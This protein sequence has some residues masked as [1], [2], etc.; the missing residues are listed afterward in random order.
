[1]VFLLLIPFWLSFFKAME[2]MFTSAATANYAYVYMA[3]SLSLNAP[4][5]CSAYIGSDNKF[6]TQHVTLRWKYVLVLTVTQHVMGGS[7]CL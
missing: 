1:M 2:D 3:Q 5:F 6:T 7:L 4:P